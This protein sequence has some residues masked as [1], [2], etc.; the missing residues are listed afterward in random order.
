[1]LERGISPHVSITITR[2]NIEGLPGVVEYLVDRGLRFSFNFY[3]EPD[4]LAIRRELSFTSEEMIAG[5]RS[6]FDLIERRLPRYSLLSN[7]SDRADLRMPHQYTCSVGI[8]YMVIDC[9]G[10]IAKCQMDMAHPLATIDAD[11][12]LTFVRA[13]TDGIQNLAADDKACR[14]CIWRYRCAGGCP[15][16]TFQHTGRYDA[17]SP[18]C[19]V[20]QAILPEVVRLEALRLIRYE[21]PWD[22]RF[23]LP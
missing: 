22:F 2:Q 1:L 8:N 13:D 3:R 5:L 17:K 7:L 11:D 21:A 23:P 20:Y 15:R 12:P 19:E 14:E 18:L 6:V 9:D 16:L 4:D 10:N